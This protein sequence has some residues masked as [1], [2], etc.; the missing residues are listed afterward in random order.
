MRGVREAPSFHGNSFGS[1][2]TASELY[3]DSF[4]QNSDEVLVSLK[5]CTTSL[6]IWQTNAGYMAK[7]K[8]IFHPKAK[9]DTVD[10]DQQLS[11]DIQATG[12][13]AH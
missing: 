9:F 6:L 8:R 1:I 2:Y 12:H 11:A 10:Q 7:H 4:F 5:L 13:D 3:C